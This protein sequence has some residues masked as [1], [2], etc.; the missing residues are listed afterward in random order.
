M[1]VIVLVVYPLAAVW[2]SFSKKVPWSALAGVAL[3]CLFQI[4]G[5][6]RYANSL[7]HPIAITSTI[8]YRMAHWFEDHLDG[9]RVFAPGSVAVWMNSF[10][11]TPQLAG[12][13]DQNVPSFEE[14][15][16]FFTV[17]SDMNAGSRA[18]EISQLWLK[19]YGVGAIG[20]TGPRSTEFY[21]PY[22][23]PNKFDG[24]LPELWRDGDNVVYGLPGRSS[25]LAHVI[26]AGQEVLRAPVNGLDVDPLRPFVTALD[27]P[28]LPL[29]D[30]RWVNSHQL[31]I[32]TTM[33]PQQVVS[34]QISYA[35]GWQVRANRRLVQA[36][37][38][39][40][41]LMVIEPTCSGPCTI[42]LIYDGGPEARW[43]PVAQ[44]IGV[45]AC[46]AWP[47]ALRRNP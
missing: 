11:D 12:C 24:I 20:M 37:A 10:V 45:L 28:D 42:D 30:A 25:S 14:R 46:I 36:H 18:S 41:G 47:L 8:E 13:C 34:V 44:W 3:L 19:A 29:A 26:N 6:H 4:R 5:Y 22:G 16:A 7:T 40:L 15:L 27:D 9:R 32:S 39:A 2:K 31:Q 17:Y 35:P 21:K 38:D 33:T 23:H 1:A 43:T